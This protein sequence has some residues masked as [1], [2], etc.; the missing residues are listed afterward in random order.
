MDKIKGRKRSLGVAAR[1]D[2]RSTLRCTGS[3]GLILACQKKHRGRIILILVGR[4]AKDSR[5]LQRATRRHFILPR[6]EWARSW[7]RTSCV[8]ILACQVLEAAG[9]GGP[10]RGNIS[11]IVVARKTIRESARVAGTLK[12]GVEDWTQRALVTQWRA[13]R[14]IHCIMAETL[15]KSTRLFRKVLP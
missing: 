4:K 1:V 3:F 8:N 15:V 7:E 12:I 14:C 6:L 9:I 11:G 2:R 5:D 10:A 13:E